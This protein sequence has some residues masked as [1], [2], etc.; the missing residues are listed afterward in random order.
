MSDESAEI[1]ETRLAKAD[2][3]A[4]GDILR[5]IRASVAEYAV[6]LASFRGLEEMEF[7]LFFRDPKHGSH[8]VAQKVS[9]DAAIN[10]LEV[11]ANLNGAKVIKFTPPK[12]EL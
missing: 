10:L 12:G 3:D 1:K 6:D 8:S 9:Y 2:A 5:A 4:R 11:M 7:V